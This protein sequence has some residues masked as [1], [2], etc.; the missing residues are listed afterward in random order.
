MD[1]S[2]CFREYKKEYRAHAIKKSVERDI[3]FAEIDE[4]SNNLAVVKEYAEDVPYPSC[5]TLGFTARNRPH[6]IVFS[7]NVQS[8]TV[9]IITI[10]EPDG[11][12]WDGKFRRRK[13]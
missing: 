12:L 3:S 4:V 5:L 7:V 9:Y 2:R 11:A 6:H 8:E 1:F 10:Y 13:I